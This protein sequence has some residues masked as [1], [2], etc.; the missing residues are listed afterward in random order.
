MPGTYTPSAFS[1]VFNALYMAGGINEIGT[2]RNIKILERVV[3]ISTCDVY[4]YILNGNMKGNV[5]F[6]AGDVIVVGPY[7]CL[8][9]ITGKVK[10][11]MYYEMKSK[12]SIGT[13]IKYAGG[14]TGDAYQGSINLIRKMRSCFPFTL[15]T[16]LNAILSK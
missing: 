14:F 7:D 11:P 5:D 4:D 3:R 1:T 2:L 13:L 6:S 16:T 12:E 8:V 15:S 9:N 10:R